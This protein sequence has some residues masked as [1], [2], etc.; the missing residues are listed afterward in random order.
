V[1][2]KH[3]PADELHSL[4]VLLPPTIATLF[5][6]LVLSLPPAD[7]AEQRLGRQQVQIVKQG[8]MAY[9]HLR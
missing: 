8:E 9:Y 7:R 2:S 6:I 3:S 1:A 5:V 4:L